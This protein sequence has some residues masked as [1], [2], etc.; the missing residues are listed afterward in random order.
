M[1]L[2]KKKKIHW[3]SRQKN[4]KINRETLKEK[5]LYYHLSARKTNILKVSEIIYLRESRKEY[6]NQL[7]YIQTVI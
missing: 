7:F 6:I 3:A 4:N 5:K 2:K 1:T